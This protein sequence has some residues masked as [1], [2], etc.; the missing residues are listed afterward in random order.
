M[1]HIFLC[2]VILLL[3]AC[4]ATGG[5]E[6]VNT[7]STPVLQTV[8]NDNYSLQYLG[9]LTYYEN[10]RPSADGVTAPLPNSISLQDDNFILTLTSFALN[11]GSSLPAFIE[12]H[13]EC[14]ALPTGDATAVGNLAAMM[15]ADTA[16]GLHGTT[17]FYA[18]SGNLGYRFSIE[19]ADSFS[20]VQADV[21]PILDSF[22]SK[23]EAPT[24]IQ[25]NHAGI[26]FSY[27]PT[28]LGD[29]NIQEIAATADQGMF[30]QPS[31]A[32][33]WIGFVPP[34][35]QRD[36]SNHWFL[37]WEP[38]L[39]FYNLNDFGS[40]ALGDHYARERVDQFQELLDQRPLTF[41]NQIPVVPP[42]NAG[43]VIRAQ[44]KWLD[45]GN[46]VGVR[47]VTQ[48]DQ[49][50]NPINNEGLVYIFQGMTTDGMFGVTAVFPLDLDGLPANAAMNEADYNAFIEN[51]DQ[52]MAA[53]SEQ[54]N[55]A[56]DERYNP[57]LTQLDA[58]LQ[59][60]NII[61]AET[62]FA[63][64][65]LDPAHALLLSDADLFTSPIGP[66]T[67][68][69]L[70]AGKAVVINGLSTD[71]RRQRILCQ[72]GA[73]GNCWVEADALQLNIADADPVAYT[74][75]FPQ[76]GEAVQVTAVDGNPIYEGPG[77]TY[78]LIGE[79]LAGE[80]VELFG[81]DDSSQWLAIVCPRNLG[82]TC[83]VTSDTAVN[84]PTGFFG[85]DGWQ[86]ITSEYVS[87]RVPGHW[88][89]TAVEPTPGSVL[90]EWHLGIPGLEGDQVIAFSAVPFAELSL[91]DLVSEEPLQIGGLPGVK[92]LRG[93]DGYLSY[94][95]NSAGTEAAHQ[96]GVG[97]FGLHVTVAE[98]DP[99]LEMMLDMVAAS[100]IFTK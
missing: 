31:P 21:Q 89:P 43:Q 49:A 9:D 69:S 1:K 27:D 11:P 60:L 66:E 61:P 56:A 25:V 98:A 39:L 26:S 10:E 47:F 7:S 15:F 80:S 63:R 2:I 35:I 64:T 46:G 24:N 59:S 79:L 62:D 23:I 81:P 30:E 70:K 14:I 67:Q 77:P 85:G 38:S 28:L 94:D 74:G 16:C 97:S 36:I 57:P 86:D 96:A 72:D 34:G 20:A 78:R 65:L 40:F 41:T 19:T 88:R 3:A 44:I 50:A 42:I 53:F 18:V 92:R 17:Y 99:E 29:I 73:T 37:A 48:F 33:T 100:I 22:V 90:A 55:S 8:Q 91:N 52:E 13:Q 84:E 5:D 71:G 58:L 95:Y 54:L 12:S 76:V 75:E 87:F 32:H 83:W 45:F 68:G 4:T 51:F 82:E 6:A 93:G